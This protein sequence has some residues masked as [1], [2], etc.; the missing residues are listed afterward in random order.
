[1]KIFCSCISEDDS[2]KKLYFQPTV[3]L[4]LPKCFLKIPLLFEISSGFLRD[5][6]GMTLFLQEGAC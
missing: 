4:S 3:L 1:M 6:M 2:E 5:G